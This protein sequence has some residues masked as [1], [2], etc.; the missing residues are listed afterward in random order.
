MALFPK[1]IFTRLVGAAILLS[2]VL[3]AG[4][5]W[6]THLSVSATIQQATLSE[7]DVDLAGLV[8]I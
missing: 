1:S 6:L 2:L 7:V 4:L 5:W 3:L 8:A